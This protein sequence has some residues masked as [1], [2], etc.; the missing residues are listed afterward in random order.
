MKRSTFWL[1]AIA[2]LSTA[3]TP[4]KAQE[5]PGQEKL[6]IAIAGTVVMRM[7]EGAGSYTPEQRAYIINQRLIPILS[8]NRLHP[9]DVNVRSPRN[10]QYATIW[11]RNHLLVTVGEPLARANNT[12][13][14]AL[15][16]V[17]A[18]NLRD[19]L[20]KMSVKPP[21][22]TTLRQTGEKP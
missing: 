11:V 12:T 6:D 20:P 19:T 7:R 18:E 3:A 4:V 1:A 17:W 9:N 2:L 13:P 15:A 21:Q 5:M 8:I 22:Q 16:R 14:T 10:E